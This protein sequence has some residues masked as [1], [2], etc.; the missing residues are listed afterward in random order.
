[1]DMTEKR[2]KGTLKVSEN[3]IISITKNAA[4]EVSGVASIANKPFSITKLFS[5]NADNSCVDAVM[6]DGVAKISL[7]IV[8]IFNYPFPL[9]SDIII[10]HYSGFVN[11]FL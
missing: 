7:S 10:T 8:V 9:R 2:K 11:T 3:V 6:L 1:M 4:L 5:N